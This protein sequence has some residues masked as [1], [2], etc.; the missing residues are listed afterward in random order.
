VSSDSSET[1]L[2]DSTVGSG[3]I[4]DGLDAI[5]SKVM[6]IGRG[7]SEKSLQRGEGSREAVIMVF[8]THHRLI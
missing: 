2:L 8:V 6:E 1:D 7:A 3:A 5:C 4:L